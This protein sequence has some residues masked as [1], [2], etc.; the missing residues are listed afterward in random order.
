MKI[1]ERIRRLTAG[2]H[3]ETDD[4][5]MSESSVFIYENRILKIQKDTEEAEN[6]YRMLQYLQGRLPV[7]SVCAS[8]RSE[9]RS[10]LLMSKCAGQMACSPENMQDPSLLCTLLAEGLKRLWSVDISDCPSDQRLSRKL[11]A[12]RYNVENGLADQDNAEPDTYGENGFKNPAAL[13]QW[14]YE[15]RP[16][17]EPVLSHGDYCLPNLFG[18][19]GRVTGYIDLGRTGIADRWCD[20]ALCWRS[21]QHNY[22]GKYSRLPAPDQLE[23]DETLLFRR[24]G[25]EPDWEKIRYYILLDE[26]F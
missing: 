4:I 7:P 12:A 16:E 23:F 11:E 10:Y 5:G 20:I 24:L 14:L 25:L 21:L 8:E 17:E 19:A 3:Y 15:N 9:G 1:P 18:I 13:L 6:E 26:L 2:E 22:S